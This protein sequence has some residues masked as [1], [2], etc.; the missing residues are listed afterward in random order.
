MRNR[1]TLI[2]ALSTFTLLTP[3]AASASPAIS[4]GVWFNYRN[5]TDSDFSSAAFND[6]LDG[7]TRGDVADEAL[8]LYLDDNEEGRPWRFSGEMRFGPG[9]FTDTDNNSSGDNFTLH[10]AWIG[11]SPDSGG[12]F[13]IG[14]SQVPFGWKTTNFWPGDLLL[15]GYGD[16]MDVGVKY[17]RS[18]GAINYAIAYYHADDWGE[19]STDTT[20]DNSHWG[21]SDS[22]RKVQTLVGN[23]D[24][25]LTAQHTVGVSLQA[26][27]LQDLSPIDGASPEDAEVDGSHSA[28]N[29]HYYGQFDNISAKAQ[30][31]SV[32]RDI[33]NADDDIEN[34]R[35]AG[36]L[37]LTQGDWFHY[38]DVTIADTNTDNNDA[39]GVSAHAI[40]TR[41][42]Y[43]PGWMY[44]EYLTSTGDIGR[45]GD[46]YEA[47]FSA[48]YATIDYYF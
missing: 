28:V 33:P 16:Q 40:G 11:Y 30:Y 25:Q 23:L 17:Q 26:G 6:E 32:M 34:W 47:D 2:L 1:E 14:K 15:G 46:T 43:G 9:S 31:I 44:L 8:I 36:E 42:K 37:G 4:G 22:Y 24:Y 48:I 38:V 18:N 5:V 27:G 35:L 29:L 21:S 12:E 7:E 3:L 45:N 13:Q 41:Y 20:D 19:T 10:K 39:D